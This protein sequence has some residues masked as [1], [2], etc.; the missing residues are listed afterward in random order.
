MFDV[1]FTIYFILLEGFYT[2]ES[3]IAVGAKTVCHDGR[4]SRDFPN[5][6]DQS[7]YHEEQG[8]G[9]EDLGHRN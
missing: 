1:K 8:K 4:C 9:R 6:I 7:R 2:W 3:E 5:K